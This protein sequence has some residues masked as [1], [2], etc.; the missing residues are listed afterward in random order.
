MGGAKSWGSCIQR[1]HWVPKL[2]ESLCNM[3]GIF[4]VIGGRGHQVYNWRKEVISCLTGEIWLILD[5]FFV[6]FETGQLDNWS[7]WHAWH[8]Y[9]GKSLAGHW[10][11]GQ[12]QHSHYSDGRP[13]RSDTNQ[14]QGQVSYMCSS[15]LNTQRNSKSSPRKNLR[16]SEFSS[17]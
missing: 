5:A 6:D 4:S 7:F 8:L 15:W 16:N 12:Y 14:P 9:S 13:V 11:G 17:C 2:T 1:I 3:L 10:I